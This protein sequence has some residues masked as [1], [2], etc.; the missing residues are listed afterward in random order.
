MAT[1]LQVGRG[2]AEGMNYLRW[3]VLRPQLLLV[4]AVLLIGFSAFAAGSETARATTA[5]SITAGGGHAC[6]LWGDGTVRCWGVNVSGQVGDG[7]ASHRDVPVKV[8]GL[9]STEGISAGINY[10]CA[11]VEGGA[12][13]CWGDGTY[14]P[15]S[16]TG[17]TNATAIAA[18]GGHTCA[19]LSDQTVR[20]WGRNSF[21]QLGDGQTC[22]SFC[23]TPVVVSGLMDVTAIDAG[24]NHTCA[25]LSDNTARCWGDN[26]EGQLGDDLACGEACATPVEIAGLTDIGTLSAGNLHTCATLADTTA[27]CWGSN[28]FGQLGDGTTTSR[29]TPTLVSGISG[30]VATAAATLHTCALLNDATVRCWGTNLGGLIGDGTTTN[31]YTPTAVSG[32]A[33]PVSLASR[34]AAGSPV[35]LLAFPKHTAGATTA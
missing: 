5:V 31:R 32:L 15:T 1:K 21:G 23:E 9:S 20:C 28:E 14:T 29:A 11:I 27:W 24:G 33:L 2:S 4:A 30:V 18:G 3:Q 26:G 6:A 25:L 8:A 22:G 19:I 34:P 17:L 13:S 35:Q 7:T 10:T 16:V 12:V